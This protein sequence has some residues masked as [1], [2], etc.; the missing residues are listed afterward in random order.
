MSSC[1]GYGGVQKKGVNRVGARGGIGAYRFF[2][3]R[4]RARARSRCTTTPPDDLGEAQKYSFA[5]STG[6]KFRVKQKTYFFIFLSGLS[7]LTGEV[8]SELVSNCP[9]F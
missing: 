3:A 6:S 7:V 2:V 4:A 5:G 1:I 8:Y 9:R